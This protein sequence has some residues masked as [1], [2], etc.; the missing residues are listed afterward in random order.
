MFSFARP[1]S[2]QPSTTV[3]NN[4]LQYSRECR[5]EHYI[6]PFIHSMPESTC[7]SQKSAIATP[8]PHPEE[9][10]SDANSILL[11]ANSPRRTSSYRPASCS[12]LPDLI[13]L[14]LLST[15]S[16]HA[17]R[18]TQHASS[19]PRQM[20]AHET[21]AWSGVPQR[22]A[23][24]HYWKGVSEPRPNVAALRTAPFG[25]ANNSGSVSLVTL[26]QTP[27]Q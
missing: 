12:C 9:A 18:A 6:P 26:V 25:R 10:V 20:A 14:L 15:C 27:R 1:T 21:A 2:P 11:V 8:Q 13:S 5:V 17:A 22:R 24:F 7:S 23:S 3:V 19:K 16:R 4:A